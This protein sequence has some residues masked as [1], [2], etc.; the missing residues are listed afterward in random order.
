MR[1]VS[2]V[3]VTREHTAAV[4]SRAK[5]FVPRTDRRFLPLFHPF[6]RTTV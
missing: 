5:A 6:P 2:V 4:G 3:P 1:K